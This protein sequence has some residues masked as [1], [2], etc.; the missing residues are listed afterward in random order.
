MH[1]SKLS[2]D[3]LMQLKFFPQV[4]IFYHGTCRN[5]QNALLP[6]CRAPPNAPN[7]PQDL[8]L[9]LYNNLTLKFDTSATQI[10]F[11]VV[12]ALVTCPYGELTHTVATDFCFDP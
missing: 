2:R 6:D 7:A 1:R 11:S 3:G 12:V 4:Q 5:A 9:C 8:R 10:A